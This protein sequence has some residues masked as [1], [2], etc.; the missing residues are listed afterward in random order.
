MDDDAGVG[1]GAGGLYVARTAWVYGMREDGLGVGDVGEVPCGAWDRGHSAG[2]D[3]SR[4]GVRER[5]PGLVNRDWA[6]NRLRG[7]EPGIDGR[8]IND[9]AWE[10]YDGCC[11]VH[12][13]GTGGADG[14]R[15]DCVGI[16]DVGG[17]PRRIGCGEVGAVKFESCVCVCVCVFACG[18]GGEREER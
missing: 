5:E 13:K 7:F 3:I 14:V 16:G 12:G 15:E 9:C 2:D 17:V 18:W 4:R 11:G 1:H 10:G 6:G 8:S